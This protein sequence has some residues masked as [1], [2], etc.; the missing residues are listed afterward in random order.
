MWKTLR[1]QAGLVCV[2]D[3]EKASRASVCVEKSSW[4]L[5]HI[6]LE[7]AWACIWS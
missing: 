2:E 5:L 3:F 7:L 6:I 4:E 1:R